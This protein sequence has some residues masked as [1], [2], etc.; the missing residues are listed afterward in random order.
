LGAGHLERRK[1]IVIASIVGIFAIALPILAAVHLAREQIID[2]QLNLVSLLARDAARRSA[3]TVRQFETGVAQL[4]AANHDDPC[5]RAAILQMSSLDVSSSYLQAFGYMEGTRVMCASV[6]SILPGGL[7]IGPPDYQGSGDASVWIAAKVGVATD[8]AFLLLQ[9]N[10]S[11]YAALLHPNLAIDV[12]VDRPGLAIGVYSIQA[13]RH[14]TGRGAFD[15]AWIDALGDARAVAFNDGDYLV[16]VQR[17]TGYNYATYAAVPVDDTRDAVTRQALLLAP[18]GLVAGLLLAGAAVLITRAQLAMPAVIKLALRR[19]EFF[20]HYQP[21]VDLAS[22]RWVGVEALIR[23]R[24]P[25]GE[26]VRPDVFIPVAEDTG[27][28]TAITGR[29]LELVAVDCTPL[30][31]LRPDFHIAINLAAQDLHSTKTVEKVRGL[32]HALKAGAG[33]IM[34]EATE[35]GFAHPEVAREVVKK[36]RADGVEVAIDDFGTGY[37]SLSYLETFEIDYLKIDKSFVDTVAAEAATSQVVLHII[38]MAKSLNLQLIAEGVETAE[39]A[40]FLRE[41]GVQYAQGWHFAK[42]M[43][44][45]ELMAKLREGKH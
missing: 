36:L 9:D 41:R 16:A 29:V 15:A 6:G 27:L 8:M 18:I 34:V 20:L 7:E 38:E 2:E 33:N 28:I 11:G 13:G 44:I 45:G 17:S 24:R 23:W 40:A 14:L 43:G 4:V 30:L 5:V 35:R 1:G 22:G 39:Q 42:P 31:K 3:D 19:R 32:K 37:S 25:G 21:I 10:A 12:A 26:F